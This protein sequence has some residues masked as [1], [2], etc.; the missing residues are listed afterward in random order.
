MVARERV[1]FWVAGS[2]GNNLETAEFGWR[3]PAEAG[4]M[5]G[6]SWPDVSRKEKP[7]I[8][9]LAVREDLIGR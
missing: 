6:S 2:W 3:Q 9:R 7:Q 5:E 1:P 4:E 8:G